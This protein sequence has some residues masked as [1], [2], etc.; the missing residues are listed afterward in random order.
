[1]S[2]AIECSDGVTLAVPKHFADECATLTDLKESLAE[3]TACAVDF[4][5]ADVLLAQRQ[6]VTTLTPDE[7][8]RVLEVADFLCN[9]RVLNATLDHVAALCEALKQAP[10]GITPYALRDLLRMPPDTPII[11]EAEV[12]AM[13]LAAS[14][15]ASGG[16]K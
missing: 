4:T 6:N 5:S 11:S 1:M 3:G 14:N 15:A 8:Y 7:A 16:D 9:E 2:V 10:G 12:D 13:L